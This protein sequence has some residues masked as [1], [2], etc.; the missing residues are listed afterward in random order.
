MAPFIKR[1][2]GYRIG[3]KTDRKIPGDYS[4]IQ[5]GGLVRLA[6]DGDTEA[7]GELVRRHRAAALGAA[8]R[9]L[10]GHHLT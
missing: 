3:G 9:I 6:R 10:R 2:E 7:F 8:V 1:Q 5:D 4:L